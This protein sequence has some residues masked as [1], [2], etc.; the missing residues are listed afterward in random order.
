MTDVE[1]GLDLL[2]D[3][4]PAAEDIP[5]MVMTNKPTSFKG[6]MLL[7]LYKAVGMGQLAY[8]DGL[9]PDTQEIVPLLVGLEPTENGQFAVYPLAKIFTKGD[10]LVKTYH[11]PDGKG[12]YFNALEEQTS[13]E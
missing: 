11:V 12:G 4:Q 13:V 3:V 6:N 7:M 8:M 2:E 1:A 5:L 9:D 10:E